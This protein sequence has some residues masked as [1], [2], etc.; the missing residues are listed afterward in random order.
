MPCTFQFSSGAGQIRNSI[1]IEVPANH[2]GYDNPR[3]FYLQILRDLLG[4]KESEVYCLQEKGQNTYVLTLTTKVVCQNFYE[5]VKGERYSKLLDGVVFTGLYGELDIPLVVHMFNPHVSVEDIELFLNRYC[6]SVRHTGNVKGRS[7]LWNGKRRFM[8]RFKPDPGG[9]EGLMH[10]PST[11]VLGKDHGYLFYNGQPFRCRKCGDLGHMQ[12]DCKNERMSQ[13]HNCG[14][15]GHASKDCKG[16]KTCSG[17]GQSSHLFSNCPMRTRSRG[18]SRASAASSAGP[19]AGASRTSSVVTGVSFADI[20]A[21]LIQSDSAEACTVPMPDGPA[22]TAEAAPLPTPAGVQVP[23][24]EE[25]A[26]PQRRSEKD[27]KKRRKSRAVGAI[28]DI[29]PDVDPDDHTEAPVDDHADV[30]SKVCPETCPE[31]RPDAYPEGCPDVC[32][33]GEGRTPDGDP[34]AEPVGHL[35]PERVSV[36]VPGEVVDVPSAAEPGGVLVALEDQMDTSASGKR[37]REEAQGE[38]SSPESTR[39]FFLATTVNLLSPEGTN[40]IEEY[41]DSDDT[42]SL[43]TVSSLSPAISHLY[44]SDSESLESL[45]KT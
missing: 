41:T 44:E 18:G 14:K 3:E 5:R 23:P 25:M 22:P 20:T 34:S 40:L 38:Q 42:A 9:V 35:V 21:G 28:P 30:G 27:P 16:E 1:K 26:L 33:E 37:S 43:R 29:H 13:C 10:P 36:G 39:K 32:P 6:T 11:V 12:S 4:V 45:K 17:C 24:G 7:G 19:S 15:W 31:D 2:V 8:V